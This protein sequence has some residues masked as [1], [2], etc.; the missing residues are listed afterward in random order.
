MILILLFVK[1]VVLSDFKREE[2]ENK[3]YFPTLILTPFFTFL[4]LQYKHVYVFTI[5]NFIMHYIHSTVN[6]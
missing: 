4:I 2:N 5:L 6:D 1:I 3:V